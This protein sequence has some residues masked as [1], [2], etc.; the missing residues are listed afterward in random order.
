MNA[1]ERQ[2]LIQIRAMA[3]SL[4]NALDSVVLQEIEKRRE[5]S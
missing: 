4:L 3:Q 2:Q 5:E 1:Q